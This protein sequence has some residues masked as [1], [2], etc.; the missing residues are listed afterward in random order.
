[1]ADEPNPTFIA[2]TVS[3]RGGCVTG[4]K[5]VR[6]PMPASRESPLKRKNDRGICAARFGLALFVATYLISINYKK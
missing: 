4:M 5:K 3:G 1:M 6:Y 2:V